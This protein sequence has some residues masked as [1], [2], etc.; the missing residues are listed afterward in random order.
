MKKQKGV[1]DVAMG[2]GIAIVVV[3][4]MVNSRPQHV[5]NSIDRTEPHDSHMYQN[6]DD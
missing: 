3:M 2:I 1:I 4:M 6:L 5:H